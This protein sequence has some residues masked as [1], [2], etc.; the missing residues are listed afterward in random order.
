MGL[1]C[2]PVCGALKRLLKKPSRPWC[3][4][5][6]E[7]T[8]PPHGAVFNPLGRKHLRELREGSRGRLSAWMVSVS[9]LP[10]QNQ[11]EREACW[12]FAPLS[13]LRGFVSGF[14]MQVHGLHT[15]TRASDSLS[16]G[17]P[18]RR[19]LRQEIPP[20]G[21]LSLI[22][23][24]QQ[25]TLHRRTNQS[26][27]QRPLLSCPVDQFMEKR[28]F[29]FPSLSTRKTDV[30]PICVNLWKRF[31]YTCTSFSYEVLMPLCWTGFRRLYYS[32]L[33]SPFCDLT[34]TSS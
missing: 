3:Q 10:S 5:Y 18:P 1:L 12:L 20:N 28:H 6:C 19:V 22:S 14:S 4:E 8:P 11:N 27:H 9:H 29:S 26:N 15:A 17:P 33:H 24:R 23:L 2:F 21:P 31:S 16:T 34:V 13:E 7:N 25:V 32:P 30:F